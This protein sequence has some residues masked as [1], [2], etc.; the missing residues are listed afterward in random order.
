M[1][2][3]D[4]A[5][6][7]LTEERF[8]HP[9]LRSLNEMALRHCGIGFVVVFPGS[10]GSRQVYPGREDARPEFCR[11]IQGTEAGLRHC[12]M[13]H[14]LMAV[15]AASKGLT[16][17]RCHAGATSLTTPIPTANQE[18]LSVLSTCSFVEGDSPVP[19]ETLRRRAVEFEVA[20]AK[21]KSAFAQVPRLEGEKLGLARDIMAAAG[22]AVGEVWRQATDERR[23]AHVRMGRRQ[24]ME[25]RAAVEHELRETLKR[26]PGGED[27]QP[28]KQNSSLLVEIVSQLVERQPQMSFTLGDIAA[29]ARVT[30]NHFS[31]LFRR[32]HNQRF[33]DFV[34]HQR[35]TLAKELLRDLT[36][37]ITEVAMRSGF[38]DPGYFARRFRQKNGV[39]PRQ[40]REQLTA[41]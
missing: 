38:D 30:P 12:R 29:A 18:C 3:S 15:A 31:C 5:A 25:V 13:C 14:M 41:G 39:S 26:D 24:E 19:W 17:Q 9:L 40:W 33:S 21:L 8:L 11:L 32:H 1:G 35:L 22:Q 37:N 20:P 16:K 4:Q 7:Y 27:K 28:R 10:E 23:L 2:T 36:L 6:V 34:T